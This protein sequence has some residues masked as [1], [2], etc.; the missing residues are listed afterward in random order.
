MIEKLLWILFLV[1]VVTTPV[2]AQDSLLTYINQERVIAKVSMVKSNYL[3]DKTAKIK[4]CDMVKKNYWSHQDPDGNFSWEMIRKNGYKW[5]AVGENVAR[6]F[7][8]NQGIV[9]AWMKSPTHKKVMLDSRYKDAGIGRCGNI[10][11]L[12][13]GVK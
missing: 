8:T 10:T 3:L 9:G 4:A 5:R 13:I 11:V 7:K 1:P 2:E 12:H 6:D